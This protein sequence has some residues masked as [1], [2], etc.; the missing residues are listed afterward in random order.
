[1][2][3]TASNAGETLTFTN[4]GA[5]TEEVFVVVENFGTTPAAGTY[6]LTWNVQ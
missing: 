5:N 1:M 6:A 3:Q 4:H 2:D